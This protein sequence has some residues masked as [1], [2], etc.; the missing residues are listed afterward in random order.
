MHADPTDESLSDGGSREAVK[1][2]CDWNEMSALSLFP[3]LSFNNLPWA[4]GQWTAGVSHSELMCFHWMNVWVTGPRFCLWIPDINPTGGP[5]EHTPHTQSYLCIP[6]RQALIILDW[7]HLKEKN[8]PV[9]CRPSLHRI[10][11]VTQTGGIPRSANIGLSQ[12]YILTN[13]WSVCGNF[14]TE[15]TAEKSSVLDC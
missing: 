11:H 2:H 6:L 14:F 7:A 3:L 13:M 12:L 10:H 8:A 4:A 5:P 15:C 9:G 1:C